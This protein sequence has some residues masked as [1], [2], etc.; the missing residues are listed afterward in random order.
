MARRPAAAPPSPARFLREGLDP[1]GRTKQRGFVVLMLVM[2]AFWA[3]GRLGP[4]YVAGWGRGHEALAAIPLAALLVPGLGHALRRLN[5]LGRPGWW[6]WALALPWVRWGLLAF[7]VLAPTSQRRRRG[8]SGW[9]LL[10]LGVAGI[11]ALGLAGSLLWTG[12]TV[13][14]QGMKPT[15]W[16]G[17]LVL[18]RRAPVTLERGD[19][20][21]FRL[22]GEAVSR[23][24]RVVALGGERVAVEGG[25]PVI[26]GVAAA[27]AE[28]GWFAETFG[29]QGPEGV[30]PVC[31]NG[32]V[33]LGAEC[34]THRF[35]ETLPDGTTYAVLDA[36]RRPLDAAGEVQ[37]P[38]GQ[39]YV[40]GDHRDAVRD[41]RLSP[42]VQG[43]GFVGAGQVIGRVDLVVA[44]TEAAH[45]WDPRGWRPGRLLEVVR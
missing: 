30:M 44:S 1:S 34:L 6:A 11:A 36:G 12:A 10:G 39:F 22:E 4:H 37:V 3:L 9:R 21:A 20:V 35:L 26:D 31:G 15:L 32:T 16:P 18:M 28:D 40:L 43:T 27:W 14:A 24:G 19:V 25:A 29:R 41:S 2:G 42:A 33:G 7:L 17:D 23:I 38:R 13:A 8:D 45:W 5:D